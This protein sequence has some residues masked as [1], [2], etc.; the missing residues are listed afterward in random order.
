[1]KKLKQA[2]FSFMMVLISPFLWAQTNPI[3]LL[4]TTAK[5]IITTLKQN[6]S[7]LKSSSE[8]IH[9]AVELYLLP[10]VDVKGMSRSVLGR[11]AWQKANKAE[12]EQFCHAFTQLVIRTYSSPLAE[13]TDESV[14]FLPL[15]KEVSSR[16]LRVNSIIQR[17][18]GPNIPLTYSL[19]SKNGAWKIYDLNVEGI[20]LLQSFRSQFAEA[21][22][23]GSMQ[24][25][26]QQMQQTSKKKVS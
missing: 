16:F 23:N 1:M 8:I 12:Q 13:Y 22:K 5:Q 7:N 2:L 17:T 24:N 18:N 25:L 6:K 10:N 26:L 20:S 21:L 14:K 11:Q 4:E 3:P 19:V 15:R 9:K